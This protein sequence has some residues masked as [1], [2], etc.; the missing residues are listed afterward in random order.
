MFLIFKI[1]QINWMFLM[2]TVIMEY[3]NLMLHLVL[4]WWT[5]SGHLLM[6]S[7]RTRRKVRSEIYFTIRLRYENNQPDPWLQM[8]ICRYYQDA[9]WLNKK[10]ANFYNTPHEMIRNG[11]QQKLGTFFN[12]TDGHSVRL[13]NL[14]TWQVLLYEVGQLLIFVSE[15]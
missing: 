7:T 6:S 2:N 15:V 11:H 14:K 8:F 9:L 10:Q 12:R 13:I 3:I 5:S 1:A 4:K